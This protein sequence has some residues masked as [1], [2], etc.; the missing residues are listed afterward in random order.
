MGYLSERYNYVKGLCDGLE[1]NGD[2]KEGKILLAVMEL[3]DEVIL[4]VE[5]LEGFR[6]ETD[7]FLDEID[8]D[9]GELEEAV[10]GDCGCGCEECDEEDTV[11]GEVE[12]PE[13]NSL[14]EL[15][16]DMFTEDGDSFICPNCGKTVEVEWDCEC[17]DCDDDCDCHE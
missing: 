12:C 6:E 13:C 3:L 11:F 17:D 10:Y 7:E 8:E 5:D 2:S 9:L 14:I 16:G 4:S 15:T 1:I